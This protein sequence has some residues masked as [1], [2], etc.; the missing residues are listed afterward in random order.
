ML[1]RTINNVN[2]TLNDVIQIFIKEIRPSDQS[3]FSNLFP[4]L[5]FT[6]ILPAP[7]RPP[8]PSLLMASVYHF[9]KVETNK[10]QVEPYNLSY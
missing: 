3:N 4:F 9:F 8:C 10:N 5:I 2:N 6:N 1:Y 7:F